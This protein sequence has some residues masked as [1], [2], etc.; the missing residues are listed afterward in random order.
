MRDSVSEINCIRIDGDDRE[1]RSETIAV[2]S[3]MRLIVNDEQ[4]EDF[5]YSSG[6]DEELVVGYLAAL[7]RG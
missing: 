4:V 1:T 5:I 3:K 2:E 6:L 7:I